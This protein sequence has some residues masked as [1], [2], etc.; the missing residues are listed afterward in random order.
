MAIAIKQ[1]RDNR[2][3]AKPLKDGD[4][5]NPTDFSKPPKASVHGGEAITPDHKWDSFN[6]KFPTG[7]AP[8]PSPQRAHDDL[9][10]S[11]QH[12][13]QPPAP[14]DGTGDSMSAHTDKVVTAIR[15]MH[16]TLERILK[17]WT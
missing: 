3:I 8:Q 9:P 6:N 7:D 17:V 14:R 15:E 13:P 16:G 5:Y 1:R 4:T 12:P 10:S 11:R 2:V